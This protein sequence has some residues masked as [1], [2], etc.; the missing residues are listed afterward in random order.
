M[1]KVC[2]IGGKLQGVEALYL[3]GKAGMETT[4]IDHRES[5]L[6]KNFC[7]RFLQQDVIEY[8][9]DLVDTLVEADFVLPA[10]ENAEVLATLKSLSRM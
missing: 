9:M 8:S 7:G 2:I 1:T 5:P 10:L 3:A 6:G 4:L